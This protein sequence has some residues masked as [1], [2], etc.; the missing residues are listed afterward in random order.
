MTGSNNNIFTVDK[1]FNVKNWVVV[2][3]GGGTGIG[4]MCAQAFANNGARVYI[5]GR[6]SDALQNVIQTHGPSIQNGGQ[7]IPITA[8]ISSKESIA[9]LVNEISKKEKY[10]N[11]LVNNAGIATKERTDVTKGE[12]EGVEALRDELW[13]TD[14]TEWEEVYRT[15][16]VGYYY[17]AV[18][19]LPLLAAATEHFHGY[20]ACILNNASMSGTTHVSQAQF[21]YNVSKGAVQHLTSLL[22]YEFSRPAVKVRVNAFSPGIFP[23]EMTTQSSGADQ[24]SHIPA[25]GFGEKKGIPADRPGKDDDIAQLVLMLACDTY[26]NGQ[27][28]HIDGGFL[29]RH[30]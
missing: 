16:V 5:V 10:V 14:Q 2:V 20:S 19:F 27:N 22:A 11:V 17:T 12:D 3:T 7:L 18:A 8:D 6:R 23:S 24:K 30:P 21:P 9:T 28:V 15:N 13:K 4:L 1:L 29:L 25:E 26:V